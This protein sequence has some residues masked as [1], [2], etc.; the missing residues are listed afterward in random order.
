MWSDCYTTLHGYHIRHLVGLSIGYAKL[1]VVDMAFVL[2][3]RASPIQF[4]I[5]VLHP[6]FHLSTFINFFL[7]L[8]DKYLHFIS[9]NIL[10]HGRSVTC[11]V[12]F[13]FI[14][15]ILFYYIIFCDWSHVTYLA[16][17]KA[18][19]Q[20]ALPLNYSHYWLSSYDHLRL[21]FLSF[22]NYFLFH[23]YCYK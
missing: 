1:L 13:Y 17:S 21:F 16:A 4:L 14:Y 12:L 5:T 18:I 22:V 23:F 11:F 15:F 20:L 10:I 3:V 6:H 2:Q 9:L 19:I 7:I 8:F